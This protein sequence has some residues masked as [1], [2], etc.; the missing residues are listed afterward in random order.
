MNY[1]QTF[2]PV[3]SL[4]SVQILLVVATTRQWHLYKMNVKNAFLNKDIS[5][6]IYVH[7]PLGFLFR[8]E[9]FVA[10]AMYYTD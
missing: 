4:T 10:Y 2:A 8:L 7:P 6:E 3:A 9:R 1:E 5:E